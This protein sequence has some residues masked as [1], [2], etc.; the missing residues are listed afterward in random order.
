MISECTDVLNYWPGEEERPEAAGTQDLV[1]GAASEEA[2]GRLDRE[3]APAADADPHLSAF[4]RRIIQADLKVAGGGLSKRP[5]GVP[6]STQTSVRP[7]KIT[8]AD[9]TTA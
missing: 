7:A 9:L 4:Y 2:V 8:F 6:Q 5:R 1:G 3:P